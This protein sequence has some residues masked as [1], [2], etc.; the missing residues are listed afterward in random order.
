MK[1][2][3]PARVSFTERHKDVLLVSLAYVIGFT[4]AFIGFAIGSDKSFKEHALYDSEMIITARAE[5][6]DS[7]KVVEK[8]EGLFMERNGEERILSASTFDFPAPVGFH[9]QIIS[10]SISPGGRYIHY[11]AESDPSVGMCHHFV[12]SVS[13][14]KVFRIRDNRGVFESL[15]DLAIDAVWVSEDSI[16]MGELSAGSGSRWILR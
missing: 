10:T 13:E 16:Q 11:C 8:S 3:A 14:D 1:K 2:S 15:N 5:A 12:Y 4:T 9:S 6:Q 7:V